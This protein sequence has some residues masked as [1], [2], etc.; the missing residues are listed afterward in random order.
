[1][2]DRTHIQWTDATLNVVDGCDPASTGC[3]RCY[4]R[5]IAH[6]F[7]GTKAY[8]N[9]FA[10]T[11]RPERFLIPFRWRAPRKVFVCSMS[12]LFHPKVPDDHIARMF[13][14]AALTPQ[15]TYQLLTKRPARMRSL[16]TSPLWRATLSEQVTQFMDVLPTRYAGVQDWHR[17]REW[18]YA[19]HGHFDPLPN[20]R[21]GVSAENQTW[22]Q[23][24][25]PALAQTPAA[26]RYVSAEPL[27]GPIDDLALDGIDQVI[28]GGESGHGARRMDPA[29]ARSIQAQ[30]AA[31][32]TSFFFKQAG[33]V[34]AREWG[35]STTK[36][37]VPADWPESFPRED[38]GGAMRAVS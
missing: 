35:S 30:C 14:V 15:H 34:L 17:V 20:V 26:C 11:L 29:W 13:V 6:R 22:A 8:P 18:L 38:P 37:D 2:S 25:I 19:R 28:V 7:A 24:R 27:L 32:H 10:V 5:D 31:T 3:D 4:A 36:G 16:L 23:R 21:L 33:A 1:M 9:G 12:D